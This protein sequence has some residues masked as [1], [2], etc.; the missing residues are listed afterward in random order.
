MKRRS[1]P[2][3]EGEGY[4]TGSGDYSGD[5]LS[6]AGCELRREAVIELP[7]SAYMPFRFDN[8]ML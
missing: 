5:L 4:L 1:N 7:Q 8:G 3:R 6:L 2:M